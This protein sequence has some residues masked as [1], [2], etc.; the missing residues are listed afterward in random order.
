MISFKQKYRQA[1]EA[2]LGTCK[3]GIIPAR[4]SNKRFSGDPN[5]ASHFGVASNLLPAAPAPVSA[6]AHQQ[7]GPSIYLHASGSPGPLAFVQDPALNPFVDAF[8]F[9]VGVG[10]HVHQ[11]QAHGAESHMGLDLLDDPLALPHSHSYSTLNPV[12]AISTSSYAKRR[13]AALE[14]S[15]N[16]TLSSFEHDDE[17]DQR[18]VTIV[19]AIRWVSEAWRRLPVAAIAKGFSLAHYDVDYMEPVAVAVA[20]QQQQ[21][22]AVL[23]QIGGGAMHQVPMAFAPSAVGLRATT[24]FPGLIIPP[25]PHA[26]SLV[27][28]LPTTPAPQAQTLALN[29][30]SIS[31]APAAAFSI[32]TLPS[33]HQSVSRSAPY[34]AASSV[35][36]ASVA[37]QP[38]PQPSQQQPE[39]YADEEYEQP[40]D[41]GSCVTTN[42]VE[43]ASV[44][45][46]SVAEVIKDQLTRSKDLKQTF[47]WSGF[48]RRSAPASS[49]ISQLKLKSKKPL[50]KSTLLTFSD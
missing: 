7:Q 27:T 9:G 39:A 2:T 36:S 6:G 50:P 17:H 41:T 13:G 42:P 1:M 31:E 44:L 29:G 47:G 30:T 49:A 10:A 16:R 26:S 18:V 11:L 25:G 21:T 33:L 14:H 35:A 45:Q 15:S 32:H 8:Q 37:Q 28:V 24:G 12:S 46:M 4:S 20:S 48:G 34:A 40:D 22:T 5:N 23:T 3:L 19:D 43:S 38:P